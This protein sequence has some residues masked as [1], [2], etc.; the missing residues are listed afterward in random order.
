MDDPYDSPDSD[1]HGSIPSANVTM[2]I[3]SEFVLFCLEDWRMRV[4]VTDG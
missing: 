3:E 1:G 4:A 2:N